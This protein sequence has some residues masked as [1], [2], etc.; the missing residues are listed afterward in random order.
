MRK[1][2]L[3]SLLLAIFVTLALEIWCRWLVKR[4]LQKFPETVD[5]LIAY[6][7]SSRIENREIG[8]QMLVHNI[9]WFAKFPDPASIESAYV[10]TS[11]TK[12]LRPQWFGI[13]RAVNGSGNSY[14]EI[15][16]GLLLQA[17]ILRLRFPNLKRVY[18]ESSLLLRRPAQLIL[19]KDHRKYLPLLTS[20]LP[21]RES[22]PD[23]EWFSRALAKEQI[24]L[25]IGKTGSSIKLFEQRDRMRIFRLFAD[26]EQNDGS[27]AVV[28]DAWLQGLRD[29]GERRVVPPVVVGQNDQKP[30]ITNDN[31]KVQRLRDIPASAPWDGLFDLIALWGKKNNIEIVFFQPPVRSDLYRFQLLNGLQQHNDDLRR[32]SRQYQVPFI[33][34]DQSELGYM[35]DWSLFSDE[36]HME[37]CA[38]VITLQAAIEQGYQ[39]FKDKNLLYPQVDRNGVS[40]TLDHSRSLC[41]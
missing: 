16:Y 34:L 1:K 25:A 32:I 29:N 40:Q 3:F 13:E 19:E 30:P 6:L 38:G 28:D 2:I 26:R 5:G 8:N 11:R 24:N 27:I 15:S 23:S 4:D 36:D 31:I 7:P 14:S 39:I 41:H 21:L 18:F 35:N 9:T 20:L 10:G 33:D 12:V 37:T 22:L 17:E